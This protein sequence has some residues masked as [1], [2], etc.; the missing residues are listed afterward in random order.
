MKPL[1][2]NKVLQSKLICTQQGFTLIEL[3]VVTIIVGIL[4]AVSLPNLMTSI[5]RAREAEAASNLGTLSRSQQ[6]YHF[7]TKE[8]ADTM[9][10]LGSNITLNTS[11]Y[12]FADPSIANQTIAKH[13]AI[14]INAGQSQVKNY[15]SGIYYNLATGNYNIA[16]CRAIGID[17]AVDAPDINTGDCSN[18]GIRLD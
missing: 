1:Q 18:G 16:I 15:A 5:G 10:K 11:Y 9:E 4:A 14:A 13:Q 2:L 3:L 7:E 12:T 8:F 6:A 17:R